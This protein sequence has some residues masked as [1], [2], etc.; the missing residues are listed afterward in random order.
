MGTEDLVQVRIR[1]KNNVYETKTGSVTRTMDELQEQMTKRK[2]I[3]K[4]TERLK[5]LEK[6]EK[7]REE[8]MRK[9]IENYELE[10]KKEE[11]EQLK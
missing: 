6:I 8:K 2:E 10:R 9:E 11:D 7:F 3:E 5:L 1:G 4:T